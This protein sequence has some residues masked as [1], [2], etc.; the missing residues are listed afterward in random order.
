MHGIIWK[1]MASA[2]LLEIVAYI[3]ADNPSAAQELKDNIEAK[4]KNLAEYPKLYR[5]GL[6][7]GTRELTA[8]PNYI[9]IY[10]IVG[11]TVE[12]LRV[13][14]AKKKWPEYT[15]QPGAA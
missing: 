10:R 15:R 11:K 14:H 7:K 12:V 9:V 8:H 3:A 2:D 6:I 1:P 5:P 4:V 13:K